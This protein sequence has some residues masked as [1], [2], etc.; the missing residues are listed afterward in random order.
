M[1]HLQGDSLLHHLTLEV[2]YLSEIIICSHGQFVEQNSYVPHQLTIDPPPTS[3]PAKGSG[4]SG[5]C[6]VTWLQTQNLESSMSHIVQSVV[7]KLYWEKGHK[8]GDLCH[9]FTHTQT[10]NKKY[11]KHLTPKSIHKSI[12]KSIPW[13]S[14]LAPRTFGIWGRSFEGAGAGTSTRGGSGE[15]GMPGSSPAASDGHLAIWA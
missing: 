2:L 12:V 7:H 10:R 1:P 3:I 6:T 9:I 13:K 5:H 14:I 8:H 4:W 15:C 11:A